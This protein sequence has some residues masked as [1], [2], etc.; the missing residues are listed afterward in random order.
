M[1][2]VYTFLRK[3]YI[4]TGFLAEQWFL[5]KT[6]LTTVLK[7]LFIFSGVPNGHNLH[8]TV[9]CQ[10]NFCWFLVETKKINFT[11]YNRMFSNT[12][13]ENVWKSSNDSFLTEADKSP[14]FELIVFTMQV[15]HQCKTVRTMWNKLQYI[16]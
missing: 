12:M 14:V 5:S 9:S 13:H 1:L 2:I 15:G 10:F 3:F 7:F 4:Y 11:V 8:F 16:Q 6:Y